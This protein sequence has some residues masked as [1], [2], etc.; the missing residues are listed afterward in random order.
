M[1]QCCTIC[2]VKSLAKSPN[3][4]FKVGSIPRAL[5]ELCHAS[6]EEEETKNSVACSCV[7]SFKGVCGG[8]G[9]GRVGI[10]QK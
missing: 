7:S 5:W 10:S 1:C 2:L 4:L 6:S 9:G 8:E 3:L